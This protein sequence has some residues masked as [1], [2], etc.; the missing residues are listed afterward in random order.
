MS[1]A[2]MWKRQH[3]CGEI[4]PAMSGT[5]GCIVNGH[6]FIFGGCSDDGQTNE[7]Y[8]VSLQDGKFMWMRLTH[9]SGSLPS[10]R[11]KLTCWL[12]KGR[13]IYFGGYGH[14][15]LNEINDPKSF[16]V[17]EASWAEEVFWGWNNEIHEFDP[18]NSSW[19]EPQTIGHSPAP[20][21]A[22]SAATIGIKGYICGGRIKEM[23]KS[24][25]YCMDFNS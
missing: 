10:P 3:M 21:A 16:V 20:R 1:G 5:C 22:H 7:H 8:S 23:R 6:L 17:D 4:P 15:R 9:Q 12:Y 24:D 13:M 25:L 2:V 18:E 19:T 11:E 14:K